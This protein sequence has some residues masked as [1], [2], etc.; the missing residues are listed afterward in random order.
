MKTIL[1]VENAY[2]VTGAYKAL[3]SFCRAYPARHIWVL[4]KGS[5]VVSEIRKEFKVYE[6]PF[7]EISRSPVKLIKYLPALWLNAYRLKKI[8]NTEDPDLIHINDLYNLVPYI[9]QIGARRKRPVFVHARMLQKSFPA[10]I[11]QFWVHWHLRRADA[12]IA[13]SQAV[14]ADWGNRPKVEVI[15]DPI[16]VKEKL[17]A[18]SFTSLP[19]RPFRF[20]YLAN[21][22]PGKGQEDALQAVKLL[23]DKGVVDYKVAFYGGTMG[24]E[25]NREYKASL[26]TFVTLNK[27]EA[28][29]EINDAVTDVEAAMKAHHAVLHFSYSE[30][31]GMVCYEALYYGLPVISS[32]CGGPAEMMEP[33]VSGLLLPVGDTNGFAVAMQQLMESKDACIKLSRNAAAYIRSHFNGDETGKLKALIQRLAGNKVY[34]ITADMPE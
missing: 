33:G 16:E 20:L 5:T 17:P 21:Y 29:V 26:Q 28:F 10:R 14:K 30:S 6:L 18:Y 3:L 22:I 23:S 4:P 2:Y 34:K 7:V 8:M 9:A 1:H 15:Y 31:F 13:V 19:S 12:I 32:D 24:L 27:L 25:S 11:Y